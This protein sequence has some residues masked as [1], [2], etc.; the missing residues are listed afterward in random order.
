MEKGGL[1]EIELKLK[2]WLQSVG[3]AGMQSL[4]GQLVKC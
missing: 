2:E 4:T 3:F 1:L